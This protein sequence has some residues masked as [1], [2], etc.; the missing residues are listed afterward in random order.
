M[1][2]QIR[3]CNRDLP[4]GSKDSL[5]TR[6]YFHLASPLTLVTHIICL[7]AHIKGTDTQTTQS[8]AQIP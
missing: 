2:D 7:D 8:K 3:Y 6:H 5:V 1:Q 4:L